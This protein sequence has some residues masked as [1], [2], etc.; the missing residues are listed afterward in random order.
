MLIGE[1]SPADYEH[2]I[3]DLYRIVNGKNEELIINRVVEVMGWK[4]TLTLGTF[5]LAAVS[6]GVTAWISGNVQQ[7]LK[8]LF[9]NR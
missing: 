2:A 8:L 6:V 5:V 9:G 4:S 1:M 3:A 7:L